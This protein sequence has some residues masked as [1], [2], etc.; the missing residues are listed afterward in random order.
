MRR[1]DIADL[2][3]FVIVSEEGSFTAAA[4]RLGITQSALSQIVRR[5]EDRLGLRLL[6]R[7]TRSVAAT[8]AGERIVQ[9]LGPLVREIDNDLA[10]LS[11]L[12][13][14]PSGHIR[15]TSVE[16]AARTV[17][18]PSLKDVLR[19]NPDINVEIVV[20]YG[21]VD[22]V[23]ERFDAGVRLGEHVEK[24]M[25]SVRISPDI[26]MALVGSPEYLGGRKTPKAPE[27]LTEHRAIHLRLS[28]A[29]GVN[30]WRLSKAGVTK[31]ARVD[32]QLTL[33]RI[34]LI[35]EAALAGHGLAYLPIDQVQDHI[36]VGSLV[37]VLEDW[38]TAL[39]G[40]HIYYPNRHHNVPAF[41]MVID[42]LKAY[43]KQKT[44]GRSSGGG[45][46]K[47]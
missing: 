21:L 39:P 17:L 46:A 40:Y 20:D 27:D 16:H 11:S 8:A 45:K 4:R 26:P 7:T 1:E 37:Q 23:A 43:A 6:T 31:R 22:V 18:L 36:V 33:N 41:R 2:T 30:A 47:K 44:R 19:G 34:D 32:G 29:S 25:I 5:L 3:A 28:D 35:L 12:R 42:A 38:T 10:E 9:R 15:I 13:D 24:D 14:T